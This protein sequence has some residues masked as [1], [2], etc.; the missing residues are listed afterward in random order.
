MMERPIA[1]PALTAASAARAT[2]DTAP[3][4]LYAER[5]REAANLLE[6]QGASTSWVGFYR[7]A[8]DAISGLDQAAIIALTHAQRT[9]GPE[10][11]PARRPRHRGGAARNGS[12]RPMDATGTSARHR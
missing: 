3:P 9:G 4:V 5:L 1:Q 2:T 12:H 11:R 8:A 6:A 10:S 7:D